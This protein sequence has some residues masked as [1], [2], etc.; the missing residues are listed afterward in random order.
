MGNLSLA[1]LHT[2]T[3]SQSIALPIPSVLAVV[4]S[5]LGT[6]VHPHCFAP[7]YYLGPRGIYITVWTIL[8]LRATLALLV[9]RVDAGWWS[10]VS[11]EAPCDAV[12]LTCAL[13]TL[14]GLELFTQVVHL[15][16]VLAAYLLAPWA[17]VSWIVAHMDTG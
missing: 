2:V 8:A 17:A 4:A 16:T 11:H 10:T 6:G 9:D 5:T 3:G 14:R 7:W 13:L 15:T 1:V 12:V